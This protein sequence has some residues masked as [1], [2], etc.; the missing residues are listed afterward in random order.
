M[1]TF[2]KAQFKECL[3]SMIMGRV[4]PEDELD[5][6]LNMVWDDFNKCP[7]VFKRVMDRLEDNVS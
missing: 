1:S 3:K 5:E 7:Y 6:I 4:L 2:T